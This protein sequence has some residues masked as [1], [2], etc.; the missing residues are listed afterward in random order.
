MACRRVI[1]VGERAVKELISKLSC[2][3]TRF[4][5]ELPCLSDSYQEQGTAEKAREDDSTDTPNSHPT[6]QKP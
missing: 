3:L 2:N 6:P 1:R 5:I 4:V